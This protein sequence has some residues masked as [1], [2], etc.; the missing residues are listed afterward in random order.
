MENIP[1]WIKKYL[2]SSQVNSISQHVAAAELKTSGEIVP[3]VVR[4]SSTIGHV[5]VILF[6]VLVLLWLSFDFTVFL[7]TSLSGWIYWL[8]NV[9]CVVALFAVAIL[10]AKISFVQRNLI[11]KADLV[12]QVNLRAELEFYEANI[13]N[14]K[15]STGILL[16]VSLMEHRAAVL[17]DKAINEKVPSETWQEVCHLLI[18][19][20]KKGDMETAFAK[21]IDRCS[22]I[23][24]PHFPVVKADVNE[25]KNHLILKE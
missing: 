1:V 18:S 15:G 11:S 24:K 4:R 6:C 19:E 13:F 5:P 20:I 3:M 23:L 21:A 17:A 16:F 10:L 9:A 22:E 7:E 12:A 14:T 2:N 25:L 8:A